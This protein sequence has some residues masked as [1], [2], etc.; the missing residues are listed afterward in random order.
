MHTITYCAQFRRRVEG[1]AASKIPGRI[2]GTRP[3]SSCFFSATAYGSCGYRRHLKQGIVSPTHPVIMFPALF[4][5]VCF[6]FRL[7]L[8]DSAE[9]Q[10]EDVMIANIARTCFPE[11]SERR[12]REVEQDINTWDTV[13]PIFYCEYPSSF[14]RFL[15][16]GYR[17]T[18][19]LSVREQWQCR[20]RCSCAHRFDVSR[21]HGTRASYPWSPYF[22][23]LM[24][25]F[26]IF[27]WRRVSLG[28]VN[29]P[30]FFHFRR[31]I[32]CTRS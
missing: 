25:N 20:P 19:R 23:S 27:I 2:G 31:R 14:I 28:R 6:F 22:Q 17:T 12:R 4:E 16:A 5:R 18:S 30:H 13:L 9:D 24:S 7:L 26:S 21:I 15:F 29:I 3:F 1:E 11:L 10:P 32:F 8:A